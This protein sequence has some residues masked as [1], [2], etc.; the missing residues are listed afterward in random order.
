MEI[1]E[2]KGRTPA[3]LLIVLSGILLTVSFPPFNLYGFIWVALVPY[4]FAMEGEYSLKKGFVSGFF[5]GF[6]HI[7]TTMY[8]VSV[9]IYTYGS[10]PA[11]GT[12]A[13][14][15]GLILILSL[16]WGLFGFFLAIL[17]TL[18][19]IWMIPFFVVFIE[20]LKGILFT[21][22]PWNLMGAALPPHLVIS[23]IADIIGVYGLS[24]I[25]CFVNLFIFR[26]TGRYLKKE[27]PGILREGIIVFLVLVSAY[28]Y[29]LVRIAEI[30]QRV[31]AWKKIR[32]CVIQPDID[33]ALKWTQPWVKKGLKRYLQMSDKASKGFHPDLMVW[34]ES[35]VTFYLN[36]EPGLTKEIR[37][38]AAQNRFDLIL[39]ATA[40][41]KRG[42]KTIFHNC[43]FIF[44][45]A[46]ELIDKY[47]KI[48]LVPFGEYIPLRKW[49]PFAKN[50]VGT[51]EDF[52]P[53]RRFEPLRS[54]SGPVGTT[55]CF[56]GIF[57]SLARKLVRKG[58]ILLVNL[59]NDAWFGRSSGPYQHLRMSAYRTV[60][61]RIYLV[62]ATGTGISAIIDPLGHV[63]A[64]IPLQTEGFIR[65]IVRKREGPETFYTR[66]GDVFLVFCVVFSV[67]ALI[68]M[69]LKKKIKRG[70]GNKGES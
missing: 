57:P 36:E 50:I 4:F 39:G 59:T 49:L 20:F 70:G 11:A 48:H 13:L 5:L 42:K 51:E 65:G 52:T 40:Y 23:Q 45:K 34:P 27:A 24:F 3:W 10:I 18:E 66:N 67:V 17:N 61:N 41:E 22:F 2:E 32:V 25:I 37:R 9:S 28:G 44:S 6:V 26:F 15:I 53:G 58:A 64:E 30:Q 38:S 62:R 19:A 35:A 12:A 54:S 7:A 55:I 21:G 29:G 63:L 1:I 43:A 46:G 14:T 60:E 31:K 33:Q 68:G 16:Y 69:G 47:D 56:E 8:W